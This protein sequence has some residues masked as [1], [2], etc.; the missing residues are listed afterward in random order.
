MALTSEGK[1]YGWGWN[2]VIIFVPLLPFVPHNCCLIQTAQ[3]RFYYILLS[4]N[5]DRQTFRSFFFPLCTYIATY[6]HKV[7]VA[8]MSFGTELVLSMPRFTN[9][10]TGCAQLYFSIERCLSSSCCFLFSLVHVGFSLSFFSLIV[11]HILSLQFGQ[12]G[13]GNN[14]DHCSPVQVHFPE[15][16]VWHVCGTVLC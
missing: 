4:V 9:L 3:A 6:I 1:L 12:V 5:T 8:M 16:Q 13:V 11:S 10:V 14:D 2:K 15:E 7:I